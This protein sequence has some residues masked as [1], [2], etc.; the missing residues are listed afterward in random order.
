MKLKINLENHKTE[1]SSPEYNVRT[2]FYITFNKKKVGEAWVDYSVNDELMRVTIESV[3]F[4]CQNR[5]DE[6]DVG[7]HMREIYELIKEEVKI[8]EY[9]T[10]IVVPI[11]V[12]IEGLQI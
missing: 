9:Y 11:N 8:K 5:F 3:R 6:L 4:A 2:C 12:Y 10:F 7:D 1:R